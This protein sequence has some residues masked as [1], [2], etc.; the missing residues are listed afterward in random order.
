MIVVGI[1]STDRRHDF[2]PTV[3]E[4]D[5]KKPPGGGGAD[6][7][8]RFMVEELFP[9]IESRYPTR[10]Y[11]VLIGHS[12]GGLLTVHALVSRP[13]LFRAYMALSPW[14]GP[15]DDALLTRIESILKEGVSPSILLFTAHEPIGREGIEERINTFIDLLREQRQEELE[16]QYKVYEDADHM[17]LLARARAP[18]GCSRLRFSRCPRPYSLSIPVLS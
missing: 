9:Q 8:L 13:E 3:R 16:W 15:E 2:T 5:G 1:A 17:N 12:L 14:F 11:K 7:F 18:V 4:G 10:D 6:D